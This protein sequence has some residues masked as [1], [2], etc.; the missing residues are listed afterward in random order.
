MKLITFFA[1]NDAPR[2]TEYNIQDF[3]EQQQLLFLDFVDAYIIGLN[4]TTDDVESDIERGINFLVREVEE[5]YKE[6][7]ETYL[8]ETKIKEL[9]ELLKKDL[10][11]FEVKYNQDKGK[12]V[13]NINLY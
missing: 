12:I 6:E 11:Y 10:H 8:N 4:K 9:K 2:H 3:T 1:M 13:F 7:E 5:Q